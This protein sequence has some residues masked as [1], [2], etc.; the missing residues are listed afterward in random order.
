MPTTAEIALPGVRV[1]TNYGIV[2]PTSMPAAQ[3]QKLHEALTKV[4]GNPDVAKQL[5]A[6]GAIPLTTSAQ[7]YRQLM[8]Q[9]SAKWGPLVKK[10][11][12][13]LD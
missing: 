8:D 11:N 4:L 5:G 13:T 7:E 6:Q 10:A 1:E 12:I 2:A 3:T 9:E